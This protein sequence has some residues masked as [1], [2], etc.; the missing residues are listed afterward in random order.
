MTETTIDAARTQWRD[1]PAGRDGSPLLVLL[2]GLGSFEGDLIQLAPYLP[3]RFTI[4]TPR[5]PHPYPDGDGWQWFSRGAAVDPE[6]REVTDSARAILAWLDDVESE[7]SSVTIG[8]FSQGGC[9]TIQCLREAPDRFRAGLNLSGFAAFGEHPNDESLATRD[10][11]IPLFWAHGDFDDVI[12]PQLI[13]R[14][15]E[16]APRH[17]AVEAH[18]Y[19][20]AHQVVGDELADV[21]AFLDRHAPA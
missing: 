12:A 8:G 19:P 13:A 18:R 3:E 1:A 15:A 20:M 21:T 4:A 11:R 9:M 14:T 6:Q 5:A 17:F 10:P 2:H 7:F 16:F